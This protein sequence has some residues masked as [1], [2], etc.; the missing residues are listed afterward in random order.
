MTLVD[1]PEREPGPGEVRIRHSAIGVNLIDTYFRTGLYKATL[2]LV[3]GSEGAGTVEAVGSGV[4]HLTV[5]DRVGYAAMTQ[6]SYADSRTIDATPV[7]KL[8]ASVGFDVA[9]AAM[10]KGLTVQYLLRRTTV[11]GGLLA[12]DMIVWHAA[13]GGVGLLAC[14]WAASLGLVVIGTA[15]SD[16]KCELA[17]AHGATHT[18]N[19]R[20]DD[21]AAR[22]HELTNGRGVKVV[23]DSVGKDT[24]STSLACLAPLGLLVTFGNASGAVP[25]VSLLELSAKSLYV[26][27][28][29]LG[30]HMA[31]REDA[32]E[33]ADELFAMLE[34]GK[35]KVEIGQ[36]FALADAERAHRDLEGRRTVGSTVLIP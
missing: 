9:A 30:T 26:T 1:L 6:G 28:P 7:V 35:L 33:M 27:R 18:I 29:K 2:P 17:R 8:P 19:Y 13:A 10:L 14:Q 5:G 12:G 3:L 20:R 32:Q 16:E 11:H 25:P 22:V 31:T 23:Y 36:R 15:G 24:W 21:V 4:T 34:T